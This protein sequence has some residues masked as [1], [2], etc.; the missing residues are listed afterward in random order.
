M[1][2]RRIGIGWAPG[3]SR[4]L[5]AQGHGNAHAAW[6]GLACRPFVFDGHCVALPER[7]RPEERC[8]GAQGVARGRAERQ[9]LGGLSIRAGRPEMRRQESGG[10]R[11]AP[12]VVGRRDEAVKITAARVLG[13]GGVEVGRPGSPQ[14]ASPR[15]GPDA[16]LDSR[17]EGRGGVAGAIPRCAEGRPQQH[18]SPRQELHLHCRA[19]VSASNWG[20]VIA[21]PRAISPRPRSATAI[22]TSRLLRGI[23]GDRG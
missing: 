20:A 12:A 15:Q 1:K 6:R 3:G 11:R 17:R 10:G 18:E 5:G 14:G 19:W 22:A 9:D 2:A 13:P 4:T 23:R 7:S 8:R 21:S 16:S